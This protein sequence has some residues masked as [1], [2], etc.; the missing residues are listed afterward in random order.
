MRRTVGFLATLGLIIGGCGSGIDSGADGAGAGG[1]G[2]GGARGT[3]GSGRTQGPIDAGS[4]TLFGAGG[5]AGLGGGAGGSRDASISE[6]AREDARDDAQ[7]DARADARTVEVATGVDAGRDVGADS[8]GDALAGYS[9]CPT[10][11]S[12]CVVMP[13]GDSIT[14]GFP[15]ENGSYRVELFHQAVQ[16]SLAITFVGRN[17]NGPQTVDSQPF[18]RGHEGYS[19]FTIDTD[20]THSGISPL[21][22]AAMAT[23]HPHIVLLQIGTNDI[24]GN[25]DIANA[26]TRLGALIDR[27]TADA[28]NALLIVAQ[29]TP[30]TNDGTNTRI[31]AY[32]AAI[33]AQVQRRAA[34]GKHV[35]VLDMYGAFTANANYKTALMFD[36]L[37]P[38][39]TGYLT[40]GDAWYAAIRAVLPQR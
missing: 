33:P 22:D 12:P 30:T 10:N 24:N 21:V 23:F 2:T 20:A 39:T 19:G 9:P 1:S 6:G 11:G 35:R 26:P 16:S 4:D 31:S 14:D 28:P 17:V 34:A 13:L 5:V 36:N 40:M 18:P 27:I 7:A 8:A 25:V 38:N 3:G 32:N 15:Y 37:H 29:I